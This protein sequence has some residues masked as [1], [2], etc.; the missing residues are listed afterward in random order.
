MP[1]LT[2]NKTSDRAVPAK[3]GKYE[4]I[5]EIGKGTTGDVYLSHDPYYGR[6]VAV[7]VYHSQADADSQAAKVARKMFF[8]EAHIVGMLQHPNILPIY[9]AGE[10]NGHYYVVMEHVRGARTLADYCKPDTLLGIEDVIK[11]LFK[12]AKALH[13]A[14]GRGLIHRDIKPSNIML[15]P[16]NDVRIIDFGIALLKDADLSVIQGIAGSPSYM[17]PEQVQSMELTKASD[18]YS[19][20]AVMYEMLTGFRPFRANALAKLLNQI[21]F[22]TPPPIHTLRNDIPEGL[23]EIVARAMQKEPDKRYPSGAEMAVDLTRVYQEFAKAH[24]DKVDQKEHFAILRRLN[25]FHDFSHGEIR[26]L[27]RAGD[28][29]EFKAGE[30]IVREGEMDDHFYVI[31]TGDCIVESN[32]ITVGAMEAGNCFGESSYVSGT[33]RTATIKARGNVTVVSVGATMLEQLSTECQLRFNKVFLSTLIRRLQ[34]VG[35]DPGN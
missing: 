22:A 29:L 5:N 27:L 6:D 24:H 13:Y 18:L 10:E 1:T 34:G 7:K 16:D 3:I 21:V 25:F 35:D 33:K 19:L 26:E 9:D 30:D 2:A 28:W 15:T 4:I 12:C 20:G 23:E 8:N 14:H 17:S 11:T 32:G 31:V